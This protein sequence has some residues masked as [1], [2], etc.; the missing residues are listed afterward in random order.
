MYGY[1]VAMV[2]GTPEMRMDPLIGAL[3]LPSNKEVRVLHTVPTLKWGE[4]G[5]GVVNRASSTMYGYIL[6][7]L[8]S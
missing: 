3:V 6:Y 5:L 2:I 1:A 4:L 8:T 7:I